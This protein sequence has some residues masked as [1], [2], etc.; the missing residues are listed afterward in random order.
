MV[1]DKNA[2]LGKLFSGNKQLPTIPELYI[3]FNQLMENPVTSNKKV[4]DLLVK[5]Q[6]MVT[7][8]LRLSNSALYGKRQEITNL[9]T[10]ITFLGIE[11]MKN[12]ILQISLVRV[13]NF[14]NKNIPQF[15]INTFWE[16]SLATAY[17][18]NLLIKKFKIPPSDNYYL[19]GLL[20]D[21]GKLVIYQY[22]PEKFEEIVLKQIDKKIQDFVA[23]EETLG[24][25]HAE[26][27]VYFA[28]KWKFKKEI[29]QAIE[30]H[31]SPHT[32]VGLNVAVVRVANMLTKTAG[33]CFPWDN[34]LFEVVGDP[35]WESLANYTSQDLD[36]ESIITEMMDEADNVKESVK[37]LLEGRN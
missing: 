16:H 28:E 15:K 7:K 25:N 20:H 17:F 1:D 31:H 30:A 10:A 11:T 8:I 23:E 35:T 22:Y 4:A 36:V 29:I 14:D 19:G 24:V 33:L 18:S 6:S 37:T 34:Q 27:G 9:A 12:L 3:K 26:I 32:S 5:D 13:F 2:I 21:I